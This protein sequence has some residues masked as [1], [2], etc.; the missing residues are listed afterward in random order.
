M[1]LY[2]GVVKPYQV[3]EVLSSFLGQDVVVE[4]GFNPHKKVYGNRG[5][6]SYYLIIR[7]SNP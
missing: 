4:Y 1:I 6:W 5:P 7:K 3:E 2:Q